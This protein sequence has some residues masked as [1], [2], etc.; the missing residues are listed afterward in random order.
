MLA[1]SLEQ[2]E[3]L[4]RARIF[5]GHQAT[6]TA[7]A[8]QARGRSDP[9]N[10]MKN[11]PMVFA[12]QANIANGHQQVNN[13]PGTTQP[14]AAAEETSPAPSKLLEEHDVERLDTGA[15]SA[16]GGTHRNLAAMGTS[17]GPATRSGKSN[18]RSKCL[19]RSNTPN[20]ESASP[21]ASQAN[22]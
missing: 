4:S 7:V 21:S 14:L 13:G 22:Q 20:V 6:K 1:A 17:H 3:R 16:P 10:A 18:R 19:E 11:P 2:H 8:R 12:K 15:Q 9:E 5:C